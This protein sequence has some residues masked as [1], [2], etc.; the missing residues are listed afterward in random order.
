MAVRNSSVVSARDCARAPGSWGIGAPGGGGTA[1]C[2]C[3][4][5]SARR[6]IARRA[7]FLTYL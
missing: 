4:A 5:P 6:A 1:A 3:P 7:R 2:A